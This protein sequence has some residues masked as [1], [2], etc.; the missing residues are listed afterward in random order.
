MQCRKCGNKLTDGV[1]LVRVNEKGVTGIWECSPVCGVPFIS[2]DAKL[3]YA[4]DTTYDECNENNLN[5]QSK[6]ID[7][8]DFS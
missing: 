4:I 1:V 5:K 8:Y 2:E 3:L 6:P 7:R